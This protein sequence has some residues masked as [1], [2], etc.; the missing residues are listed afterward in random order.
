MHLQ[1]TVAARGQTAIVSSHH[2]G[3]ALGGHNIEQEI[4]DHSTGAFIQGTGRFV[5]QQNLRLVH[6][7]A[8]KRGALTLSSREFLNAMTETMAQ[9]GALGE[10]LQTRLCGPAIHTRSYCWNQTVLFQS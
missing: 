3:H 8:A 5:R 4:K 7:R 6:Q 2:Q 9:T 1:K 10:L